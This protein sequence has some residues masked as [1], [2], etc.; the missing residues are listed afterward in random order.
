MHLSDQKGWSQDPPPH[1]PHLR[2]GS[3][4]KGI[5]CGGS[6]AIC[7]LPRVSSC[8][9]S[10]F[11]AVAAAY[12]LVLIC[13]SPRFCCTAVIVVFFHPILALQ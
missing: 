4:R 1:Q 12:G 13:C 6:L 8:F 9:P 3:G 11:V 7:G 2:V 5:S 10:F